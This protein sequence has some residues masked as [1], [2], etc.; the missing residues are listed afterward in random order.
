MVSTG[1]VI[2]QITLI[3]GVWGFGQTGFF[4]FFQFYAFP[5]SAYRNLGREGE[6][7]FS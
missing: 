4:L 5:H 7:R 3:K 6:G 1:N 2:L